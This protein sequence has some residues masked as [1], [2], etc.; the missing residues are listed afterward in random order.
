MQ[1]KFIDLPLDT[2]PFTVRF[3]SEHPDK[4]DLRH[5]VTVS[6]PGALYVPALREEGD[7]PIWVVVEYSDGSQAVVS[8]PGEIQ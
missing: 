3:Y 1:V 7:P 5:T 2:F 8:P 6:A 4:G